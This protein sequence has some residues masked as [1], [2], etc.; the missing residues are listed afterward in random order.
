[1]SIPTSR[2]SVNHIVSIAGTAC[3]KANPKQN[4]RNL[5]CPEIILTVLVNAVRCDPLSAVVY[6]G[7][8]DTRRLLRKSSDRFVNFMS[9]LS[10]IGVLLNIQGPAHGFVSLVEAVGC[11]HSISGN[12]VII[13]STYTGASA[14]SLRAAVH[15]F[16]ISSKTLQCATFG[17]N[18]R[19]E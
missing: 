5:R 16:A 13:K 6:R 18:W 14:A 19:A 3:L 17:R 4:S 7:L 12:E 8:T 15:S 9:I 1:M 11:E 2:F 10:Q